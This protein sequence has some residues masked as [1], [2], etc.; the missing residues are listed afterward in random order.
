MTFGGQ[1]GEGA[2]RLR[3]LAQTVADLAPVDGLRAIDLGA[4]GGELSVELALRGA[5]V[6]AI[7]GERVE[8]PRVD[9]GAEPP[10]ARPAE[11]RPG[12]L[13]H[14]RVTLARMRARARRS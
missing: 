4:G 10:N 7:A 1:P 14:A 6:V 3:A 11:R 2:A 8:R 13:E 5:T 9:A 12:R